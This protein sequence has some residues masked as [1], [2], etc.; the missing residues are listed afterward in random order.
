MWRDDGYA[1]TYILAMPTVAQFLEIH[2]TT[3]NKALD[4]EL[5]RD[6]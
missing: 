3:V 2:F 6:P 1:L 4:V 5:V